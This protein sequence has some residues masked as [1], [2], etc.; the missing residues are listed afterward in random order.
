METQKERKKV[1]NKKYYNEN[2]V[3]IYEHQKEKR[4]CIH[5]NRSYALYEISRHNKTIKHIKNEN[6][7][8]YIKNDVL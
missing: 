6:N 1:W 4:Y 3:K 7:E 2:K 5:C 8:N